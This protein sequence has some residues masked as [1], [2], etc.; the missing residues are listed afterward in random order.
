MESSS[1]LMKICHLR[2]S[3]EVNLSVPAEALPAFLA[4]NP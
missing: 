3:D 1:G 2:L 4:C